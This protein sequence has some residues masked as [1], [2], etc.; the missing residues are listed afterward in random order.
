M[1]AYK[2]A[3]ENGEIIIHDSAKSGVKG[4]LGEVLNYLVAAPEGFNVV[5]DIDSFVAPILRLLPEDKTEALYKTGKVYLNDYGIIYNQGKSLCITC[6]GQ[7]A[8]YYWLEQYYQDEPEPELTEIVKLGQII[9]KELASIG[10]RPTKLTSSVGM[11]D[12]LLDQ[13]RLPTHY[14]LPVE[15]CKWTW[16]QKSQAWTEAFKIGHFEDCTDLDI[17]SSFPSIMANLYDTRYGTWVEGLSGNYPEGAKYVIFKGELNTD[18]YISPFIHADK[19]GRLFSVKGK[20]D[21]ILSLDAVNYLKEYGGGT[22]TPEHC[23]AWMPKKLF[24][25]MEYTVNKLYQHRKGP[26]SRGTKRAIKGGLNG[27]YGRFYQEFK[28][29]KLGPNVNPLWGFLIEECARLKLARYIKQN[30]LE[31]RVLS[32]N[33]DGILLEGDYNIPSSDRIGEWRVDGKGAALIISSGT[34]FFN[35]KKPCQTTYAE[36][37]ELIKA[38][39]EANTWQK[40]A[41]RMITIGDTLTGWKEQ[42][43]SVVDTTPSFGLL[44]EHD[45]NFK[46]LPVTGADLLSRI[47]T[48][49]PIDVEDL[50]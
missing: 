23:F 31:D 38:S 6:K 45:R 32:I 12:G 26:L 28:D 29:G 35:D 19:Y 41:R 10:V 36:A 5:W 42:L 49:E 2:S 11:F 40:S 24:K 9:L 7:K 17:N 15:L 13:L 8:S 3:L 20:R 16:A 47:Y 43:G 33:T 30:K 34:V 18:A 25:P 22:F 1:I 50:T 37:I 21:A 39:P 14:D 44:F 4:G 48:S 27:F 46:E